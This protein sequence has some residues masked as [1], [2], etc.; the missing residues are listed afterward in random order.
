MLTNPARFRIVL[1]LV[2]LAVFFPFHGDTS[3]VALAQS[4]GK[5]IPIFSQGQA[6]DDPQ[7]S[8]KSQQQAVQDFMAQAV[9]QAVGKYLSPTQMGTQF[10]ALQKQILAHPQKYIDSYQVFSQ[11]QTGGLYRVTG[12]VSVSIDVLRKDLEEAGFPITETARAQAPVKDASNPPA[13]AD[14]PQAPEST[15]E[16]AAETRVAKTNE[17]PKTSATRGLSVTK[18][19]ILWVVCEKWEQDWVIPANKRDAQSL[20]AQSIKRELDDYDYSLLYAEPGSVKVDYTGN[21]PLSQVAALAQSLGVQQAVVG[22]VALKQERNR[23]AKL[24]I[25]LRVLKV[26]AGKTEGNITRELGMEELS[27]QDG[28]S[29]LASWVAPQLNSL[30]G[31]GEREQKVSSPDA[32]AGQAEPATTAARQEG[33]ARWTISLPSAQYGYWKEV[34]RALREQFK[35]MQVTSLEMGAA[36]G[37][38]RLDGVDGSFISRMNGTSLPSGALVRIDSYSAETRE[39]KVSFTPPGAVKAEPKQ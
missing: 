38:V 26:A 4:P 25:S 35:S 19:E 23:P 8:A 28:A 21:I 20:F 32:P 24:Q 15:G 9:M 11:T 37:T 29:E 2:F 17:A 30:L 7:D 34:E 39:I 18:K 33:P 10:S 36:E 5:S 22:A 14:K 3:G 31:A 27:N 1:F 6:V 13:S 16:T 12:Q